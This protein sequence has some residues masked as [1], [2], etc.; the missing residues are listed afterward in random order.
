MTLR[1]K[2][3]LMVGVISIALNALLWATS[4]ILWIPSTDRFDGRALLY[5]DLSPL[6]IGFAFVGIVVWL[7]D[8]WLVRLTEDKPL[9]ALANGVTPEVVKTDIE[10][11]PEVADNELSNLR[12]TVRLLQATLNRRER[13]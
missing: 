2:I 10:D 9:K 7:T 5:S 3:L 1:T 13:E 11:E 4:S 12:Q 8:R 6:A